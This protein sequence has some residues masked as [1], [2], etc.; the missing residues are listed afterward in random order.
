MRAITVT[1]G[2]PHS[3]RLVEDFPEPDTAEGAV[4]VEAIAVGVCGTDHEIIRGEY[5]EPA[6]GSTD[7]VL[8]HESLGRVVEDSSGALSP[9]DVVAGIVRYPDPVPCT[10]CAVGEWDMCRNGQYTEHGIKGLQGFARDRWRIPPK[11]AVRLD[12]KLAELG[13][14]LEPTSVVAKAW[15]HIERIGSRAT[16]EPRTVLVAGAGPIGLLAALLAAQRGLEVHVLNRSANGE[17]PALVEALGGQF[18]TGTVHELGREFDI[19]L[20]CTGAPPVVLDSMCQAAPN[21]IVCLTGVSSGGRTIDFDAGALNR[22]LVLEN[23]VVFGTVN[24]NRRH[25]ES[26]AEAL[27]AADPAWLSR[28]ITRRVPVSAWSEA[29]SPQADDIKVVLDFEQ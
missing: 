1:P 16:W 2:T 15:E 3:V 9:G 17:K 6:P 21:G 24:A 5:G 11:F 23:N 27:A 29:Y 14:L 28:M 12:P 4:L 7:L 19:V 26:A 25:W 8:G 18:H 13:M 10:N 20:E 22:A